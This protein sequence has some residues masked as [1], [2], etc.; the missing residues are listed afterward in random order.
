MIA[1]AI[2]GFVVAVI[3]RATSGAVVTWDYLG[4]HAT[5]VIIVAM[6]LM[7]MLAWPTM[8]VG[9]AWVNVLTATLLG[10]EEMRR[11]S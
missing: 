5:S 10:L 6:A 4:N 8:P 7:P 3:K 1:L 2:V 9:L 11:R